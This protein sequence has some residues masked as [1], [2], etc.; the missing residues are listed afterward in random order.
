MPRILPADCLDR[1]GCAASGIAVHL[2]KD[3]AVDAYLFIEG[4]GHIDSFLSGHGVHYKD[5]LMDIHRFLDVLQL[6]HHRFVDLQTSCCIEDDQV[7]LVLGCVLDGRLGD[8]RGLV[9]VAHREDFHALLFAVDLQLFDRCGPVDVQRNEQRFFALLLELPGK[10]RGGR[11]LTCALKTCHHY[12]RHLFAG[13]QSELRGLASHQLRHLF[14]D[15]LDDHLRRIEAVHD[16]LADR[17][18]LY[19]AHELLDHL[20]VDVRFEQRHLDFAHR[21]LDIALR[22]LT[23]AAQFF[24]NIV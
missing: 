23:L 14:V 21:G 24:E 16:L 9:P 3:N 4:L 22:E 19:G 12:D 17:P 8:V 2:G 1:Q 15:D 11:R 6:L 10:F 7:L 20:E 5:R 18:F 13:L